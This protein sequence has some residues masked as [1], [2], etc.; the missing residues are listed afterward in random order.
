[1]STVDA[2]HADAA[3]RLMAPNTRLMAQILLSGQ[4]LLPLIPGTVSRELPMERLLGQAPDLQDS[5]ALAFHE[6]GDPP[7]VFGLFL[8]VGCG[9][10]FPGLSPSWIVQHGLAGRSPGAIGAMLFLGEIGGL[11]GALLAGG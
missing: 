5:A 2:G 11:L 10:R 6:C 4:L 3:L 1:M 9:L 8:L 7:L